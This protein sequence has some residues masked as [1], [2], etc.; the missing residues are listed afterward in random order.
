MLSLGIT[1]FGAA[2]KLMLGELQVLAFL[3]VVLF[4]GSDLDLHLSDW[5]CVMWGAIG[6]ASFICWMSCFGYGFAL[7]LCD[8]V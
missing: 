8:S 4:C 6:Y 7:D 5:V 1:N 3:D 2:N